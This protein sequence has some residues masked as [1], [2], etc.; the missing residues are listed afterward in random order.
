MTIFSDARI[1]AS[2]LIFSSTLLVLSCPLSP[3]GLRNVS[4][5]NL[6]WMWLPLATTRRC[7]LFTGSLQWQMRVYTNIVIIITSLQAALRRLQTSYIHV[8][9]PQNSTLRVLFSLH[10]KCLSITPVGIL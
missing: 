7:Q 4:E 1:N 10:T 8:R 5:L 6:S 2:F 9:S 3:I